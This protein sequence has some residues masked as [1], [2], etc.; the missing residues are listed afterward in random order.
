M[1]IILYDDPLIK[2]QL[3]PLTFI[4]PVAGIRVG[5]L[6]IA[7]KWELYSGENVSYR[8]DDY[9]SYKFPAILSDDSMLINGSV[10]PTPEIWLAIQSLE[11]GDGEGEG[12][13]LGNDGIVLAARVSEIPQDFAGLKITK[14][15][16]TDTTIIQHTWD[17]F[18]ENGQQIVADFKLITNGRESQKITDPH[19]IIYGLENVFVEEGVEFKAAIINAEEGPVYIGKNAKIMEG[20]IMRGPVSVGE[21]THV[22]MNAKVRSNTTL[23]PFCRAGGEINNVVMFGNSNKGHEGFLGNAVV[24]EWCNIGADTNNSNL[25]NNYTMVKMWDYSQARFV[26]TGRQFCGLV[27]GDHTK[28]GINTMFN[29][30][31][32]IGIGANIFGAGFPRNFIPSFSWGGAGGFTSYRLER[33]FEMAENMMVRRN[34][35]LSD[36]DRDLLS[37]IFE[38][39]SSNRDF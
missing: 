27:M 34:I 33:F 8:V 17:I 16:K 12:E 21:G 36:L 7:E 30:G 28:C 25:K 35:Q 22:N 6:T 11:K 26:K 13:V 32:V 14:E 2:Q 23:G 15:I 39:S 18:A 1:N 19:T 3:L 29:T 31:T 20:A 9:L 38:I 5:I 4:R 24:G 37:H 10:C